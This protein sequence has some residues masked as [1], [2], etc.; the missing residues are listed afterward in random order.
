MHLPV[1]R[2]DGE[3]LDSFC[4]QLATCWKA[5]ANEEKARLMS[6]LP[7]RARTELEDLR[8]DFGLIIGDVLRQ[9]DKS[10]LI[11]GTVA[12]RSV[13]AKIQL[14]DDPFWTAKFAHEVGVYRQ[15][16]QHQ[17]PVPVPRLIHTDA[18]VLVLERLD[19]VALAHGRYPDHTL[20]DGEVDAV[21]DTITT[22][23]TWRFPTGAFVPIFD[24]SERIDRYHAHGILTAGDADLLRTLLGS[25]TQEWELSHGDPLPSNVL[26]LTG[27]EHAA[28]LDLEFT[29]LFLPGFDLALLHTLLARTPRAR[30]RIEHIVGTRQIG[31]PFAINLAMVL[32]REI[33]TH[34]ELPDGAPH[35][36][37]LSLIEAGWVNARAR[38]YALAGR[39]PA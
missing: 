38:L 6:L 29:G 22:L 24:Y 34:R 35:K 8:R 31:V 28:L 1:G 18:Q 27:G 13:V 15:F 16:Q 11:A 33:R 2:V 26:V 19:G 21:I 39:D 17:P 3:V 20:P 5:V 9:T 4:K 10:A 32:T 25:C 7:D 37:H 23:N 36:Q 30:D 14:D 12:S